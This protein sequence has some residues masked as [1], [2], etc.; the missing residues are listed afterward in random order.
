MLIVFL[1]PL[2]ILVHRDARNKAVTTA[3]EQAITIA[4]VAPTLTAKA[5][6]ATPV[7][8]FAATVFLPD[9]GIIGVPAQPG[10]DVT[11]ARHCTPTTT[12][13]SEG[14]EV[15]VPVAG[16][17]GCPTV[18]RVLADRTALYEGAAGITLMLIVI[19]I[20][21]VLVG[22][23]LAERLARG[24]LRSVHDLE[25]TASAIAG[26]DLHARARSDGPAEIR[27]AGAQLNLLAI[28]VD[29]LLNK[30]AQRTADL[31]HRLRTPLT[32]LRLDIDALP[33]GPLTQRLI[34][35][36][37]TLSR[38]LNEV[39]LA[40]RR[41]TA[42]GASPAADLVSVVN[43]R[44]EFWSVLAEETDRKIS[45]DF[46]AGPL[47]IGA[48][49]A[50]LAAALDALLGNI[51]AHTPAGVPIHLS[52]QRAGTDA[53]LIVDDAGPGFP[54]LDVTVRGRSKGAST[55]LGLDIARHT[56]EDSGGKMQLGT[57]P[58]GGARVE[59]LF[60]GL[61]AQS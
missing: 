1:I 58:G 50:A 32:S 23:L 44:V 41:T 12:E 8:G 18:V 43:E 4:S 61:D 7:D 14:V 22:A 2:S 40:A 33:G 13:T 30:Q 10:P 42:D 6:S 38:V 51:F 60:G 31:A 28:R 59:L 16:H 27:R 3:T 54:N 48:G 25:S 56:A 45:C 9:G 34:H 39:I 5:L 46:C 11:A 36:H 24:L 29:Q 20:A 17:D 52:I 53:L 37:D 15:L 57:P 55:G 21:L 19:S 26:G 35:D 49:P 47:V